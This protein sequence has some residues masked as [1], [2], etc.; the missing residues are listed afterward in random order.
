MSSI[1]RNFYAEEHYKCNQ[2]HS[3]KITLGPEQ[4][5][6]VTI[7]GSSLGEKNQ[8]IL[9]GTNQKTICNIVVFK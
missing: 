7:G 8:Y 3:N 2:S 6:K 1:Q 5:S 4:F 9:L